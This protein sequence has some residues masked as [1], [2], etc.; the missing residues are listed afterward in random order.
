MIHPA[1]TGLAGG[2]VVTTINLIIRHTGHSRHLITNTGEDGTL[3]LAVVQALN[4]WGTSVTGLVSQYNNATNIEYH[5]TACILCL[6]CPL[7]KTYPTKTVGTWRNSVNLHVQPTTTRLYGAAVVTGKTCQI[8]L[9]STL[10][11]LEICWYFTTKSSG[12]VWA[13]A[14]TSH[15]ASKLVWQLSGGFCHSKKLLSF[16]RHTVKIWIFDLGRLPI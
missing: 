4:S 12:Q 3:V 11:H 7:A 1:L 9:P 5:P 16:V 14:V 2:G 15:W 10:S 13:W 6:F 8:P